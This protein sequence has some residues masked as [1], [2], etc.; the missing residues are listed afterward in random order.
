MAQLPHTCCCG[1]GT[2]WKYVCCGCLACLLACFEP[3]VPCSFW[4]IQFDRLYI[5]VHAAC[6]NKRKM[7]AYYSPAFRVQEQYCVLP[8]NGVRCPFCLP[9]GVLASGALA[10]G[11]PH[12]VWGSSTPDVAKYIR[13]LQYLCGEELMRLRVWTDPLKHA[14]S[15]R[16][17][18]VVRRTVLSR[19][20]GLCGPATEAPQDVHDLGSKVARAV[21]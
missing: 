4:A 10:V 21:M 16:T 13:L 8:F 18:P 12:P 14:D 15:S 3:A 9:A 2:S 5:G 6:L 11:Q 19:L 17:V 7:T 20:C 1:A